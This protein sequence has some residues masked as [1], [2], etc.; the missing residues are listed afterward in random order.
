MNLRPSTPKMNALN[1]VNRDSLQCSA[2]LKWVHFL[3][4]SLTRADFRT[5]CATGTAVGWRCPACSP[6]S[7]TGS[8]TQTSSSFTTSASPPPR[9][10]P[11]H[12]C[13]MCSYEV[14]KD[15]LKCSTCSKWVHFSCSSLTRANFRKICATGS[16]MCWNCSACLNGD[17]ASPTHQQVSPRPV[18]PAPPPPTHPHQHVQIKWIHLYLS[19]SHPPIFNTYPFSAFTLPFTSP[20][21]TSTQPIYNSP[22]HPQRTPRLPQNLRILQWNAGGLSPSRRA[23]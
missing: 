18:S 5:I 20:P 7:Q 10:P 3:C 15:S 12:P 6:Q 1:D 22:P 19:P 17:L 21:P 9:G 13:S 23:E 14:G 8:P 11:H 2:C 4:S 16:I